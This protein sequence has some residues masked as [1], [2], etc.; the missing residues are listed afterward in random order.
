MLN[1]ET[2][3][4]VPKDVLFREVKDQTGGGTVLLN[5][6]SGKYFILDDVGTR[7]WQLLNEHKELKPAAQAMLAEYA[8]EQAQLE[9]DLLDLTA[10][11]VDHGLLQVS[12]DTSGA[13]A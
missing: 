8:V 9:Q 12:E 2:K 10:K 13:E 11:L 4:N 7:I 3:V 5:L 6:A 1:L